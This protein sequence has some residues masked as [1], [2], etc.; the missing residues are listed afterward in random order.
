MV[1]RPWCG[2]FLYPYFGPALGTFKED[3]WAAELAA[4]RAAG[5]VHLDLYLV[6]TPRPRFTAAGWAGGERFNAFASPDDLA[7]T[8]RLLAAARDAGLTPNVILHDRGSSGS[9]TDCIDP[10]VLLD[11]ADQV[12]QH[13]GDLV[14][15]MIPEMEIDERRH[16]AEYGHLMTIL[17]RKWPRVAVH[18]GSHMDQIGADDYSRLPEDALILLQADRG[19]PLDELRAYASTAVTRAQGRVVVAYEHSA[20]TG[21]AA[22]DHQYDEAAATKRCAALNEGGAR[23]TGNVTTV[24]ARVMS[25]LLWRSD[26]IDSL[27]AAW[28]DIE[29]MVPGIVRCSKD[30]LWHPGLKGGVGDGDSERID[31]IQSSTTNPRWRT[32]WTPEPWDGMVRPVP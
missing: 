16:S 29:V 24:Q 10:R 7:R 2:A 32:D 20:A 27:T 23:W 28:P 14:G 15:W 22:R 13:F 11:R 31:V 26:S 5:A 3:T 30:T 9:P 4:R 12:A 1:E 19:A 17:R 6:W 8:G 25:N 18:F 21:G